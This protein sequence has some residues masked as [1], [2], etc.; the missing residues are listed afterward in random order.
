[1]GISDSSITE[2]DTEDIVL[3]DEEDR[4]VG[5]SAKL[6]AHAGEGTLHRA[7]SIFIFNA[8]GEMLLQ[9]RAPQKYH[10]GSRWTNACC[11]HPRPDE[12]IVHAAERRLQ[13]EF[14]FSTALTQ[15]FSFIYRARDPQTGLIEHEFDHVLLG[16]FDGAPSPN[17]NEIAAWQWVKVA[18]LEHDLS[19]HPERYTP[20]FQHALPQVLHHVRLTNSPASVKMGYESPL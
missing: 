18:D 3:V 14:G 17:P 6:D 19:V 5:Y 4:C 1:M 13:E 2:T 8:A 15:L 20:W 9:Q 10:F 11:S 12:D 7:F 16:Q